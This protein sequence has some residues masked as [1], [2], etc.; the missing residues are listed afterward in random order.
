MDVQS[1]WIDRKCVRPRLD[2]DEFWLICRLVDNQFWLL[3]RHPHFLWDLV[4]VGKLRRKL[5]RTLNRL[6]KPK[7]RISL[8]QRLY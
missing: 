4:K 3:R 1:V 8:R 7:Y 2:V 6:R 5:F